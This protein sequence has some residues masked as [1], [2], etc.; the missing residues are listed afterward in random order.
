MKYDELVTKVL[1]LETKLNEIQT[2]VNKT[3]E[4]IRSTSGTANIG[5][6]IATLNEYIFVL[7]VATRLVKKFGLPEDFTM[8][9][10]E[11]QRILRWIN[12]L[13]IAYYSLIALQAATADPL[14]VLRAGIAIGSSTVTLMD[15][16]SP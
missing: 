11:I 6:S 13:K 5:L 14:T 15:V 8:I 12:T 2:S 9:V 7:R 4:D 3:T 16:C 10:T 1:E